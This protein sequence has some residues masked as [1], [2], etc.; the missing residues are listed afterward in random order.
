MPYTINRYNGAQLAVIADGTVDTS[1][2]ITLIGKNYAGYG[3]AQNENFL[4]LLENFCNNT[5]PP[6]P[7]SGQVW[8][9]SS[10]SKLK[11]YDGS[12]FRACGGSEIGAVAPTGL[13]TGDF[14]WDTV[15]N[16]LYSWSG[17]AYVLVGPQG[18]PGSATTEMISASVRDTLGTA[19]T[20]IEAVVNGTT[21]YIISPDAEFTLDPVI[22][23][24]TGFTNIQQGITLINTN[25]SSEPGQTQTSHR[26]WGTATN[27]DRLGGYTYNQFVLAANP[28]FTAL[29]NFSDA[30]F[31]IG[32]TPRLRVYN[33]GSTTPTIQNQINDTIVFQTTVNSATITPMQLVGTDILPGVDNTTNLGSNLLRFST[34]NAVTFNGI[35]TQANSVTLGAGSATASTTAT[36]GTI[37]ART[38]T[39]QVING[40]TIT[41]GAVQGTY[42]VGT[43]TS[44][45]YADL[46]EKYLAD[47]DYEVGTVVMIGGEKEVTACKIGSR[48]IGAVSANPAYMMNAELEGGTF[49]ALK[50]RVPVKVFGPVNKGDRLIA[51]EN[52][53]ARV[54]VI[55]SSEVFAIALESNNDNDV[56]LVECLVL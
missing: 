47:A 4:Y 20:V 46:A 26:F 39:N 21:V 40:V 13:T 53:T 50:G 38:T 32:N 44:A 52:G 41:A 19:H 6:H 34:V 16:Q 15:N 14:W 1:T 5:A 23:P 8:F 37:V 27:S 9:D 11:F 43:A 56:K 29:A 28:A 55:S 12:K 10:A 31:T 2:D 18:V 22:N 54:P 7:I 36:A 35:A 33:S 24:I 25:N 49:I 45:N 30:G 42:F 51:S 17:S 48:A 3:D